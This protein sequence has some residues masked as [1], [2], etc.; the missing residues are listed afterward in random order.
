MRI[1]PK[2]KLLRKV[3]APLIITDTLSKLFEKC[4]LDIVGPLTITT[5]GNKYLL[6][7][8]DSLTKFNK[9]IPIPN[10]EANMI[11]VKNSLHKLYLNTKLQKKF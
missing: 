1:V 6:T 2:N 11:K 9:V 3:K 8:Q 7:F 10:Q 5:Q 4:A